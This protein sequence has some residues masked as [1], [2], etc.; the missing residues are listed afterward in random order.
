[1]EGLRQFAEW[2]VSRWVRGYLYYPWG[3]PYRI[4]SA[5]EDALFLPPD[6]QPLSLHVLGALDRFLAAA[7]RTGTA[8]SRRELIV[9]FSRP[10]SS[11]PV[12]FDVRIAW[13]SVRG[14]PCLQGLQAVSQED[15]WGYTVQGSA[16]AFVQALEQ[17]QAQLTRLLPLYDRWDY[18]ASEGPDQVGMRCIGLAVAAEL[19]ARQLQRELPT[20]DRMWGALGGNWVTEVIHPSWRRARDWL[21]ESSVQAMTPDLTFVQFL[22]RY[23]Q[24]MEGFSL[25]MARR[26]PIALSGRVLIQSRSLPG[27][28]SGAR[29]LI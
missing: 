16:G 18:G 12:E 10:T 20:D 24:K 22:E 11:D 19:I 23:L 4:L 27:R 2:G 6:T 29:M 7:R 25:H 15:G 5:L 9:Y 8:T 14:E 21:Y 17:I 28:S 26:Q 3:E 13:E 1:M